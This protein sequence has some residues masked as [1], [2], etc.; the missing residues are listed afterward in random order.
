MQQFSLNGDS[1]IILIRVRGRR[2]MANHN[3]WTRQLSSSM[4]RIV[5]IGPPREPSRMNKSTS[6]FASC[7]PTTFHPR[8]RQS[9]TD[10]STRQRVR[11]LGK[12][13]SER[14]WEEIYTRQPRHE[15]ILAW[16]ILLSFNPFLSITTDKTS[17]SDN[18]TEIDGF[19]GRP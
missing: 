1:R 17:L 4:T 16:W 5:A 6:N 3:L 13:G 12:K 2:S 14:G 11:N 18:N 10:D 15:I 9:V 19:L 7:F 8:E